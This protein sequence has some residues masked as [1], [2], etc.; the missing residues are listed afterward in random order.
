MSLGKEMRLRRLMRP[1]TGRCV[2]LA[3]SH[4]TSTVEIFPELERT[5][6][7]LDASLAGG[8]DCVLM[9]AGFARATQTIW[10]KY[11]GKGFVAKI[12]A[13]SYVDVP[14]EVQ[15][16]SVAEAADLGADGVGLLMQL[17]PSTEDSVLRLVAS[18]GEECA[19]RGMPYLVEAELPGAYS[20]GA[21]LPDDVVAYLRRSCRLAQELGADIIKT[22]W[23]G[24]AEAFAS[25]IA[26]VTQP[27]V[28][29][30]GAKTTEEEL[31][32]RIAAALRM[33]AAGAS[34]GRNI[35]I[36]DDPGQATAQIASVVHRDPTAARLSA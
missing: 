20:Q 15:I 14:R 36:S 8:A 28:V 27:V 26:P 21:W 1:D 2:L 12:S 31:L 9:S 17:T 6:E 33:G 13:T 35:F 10:S 5:A 24:S 3:L 29:A 11:P 16:L 25:V 4:G 19:K 22:N 23:P 32:T 34:V 18:V 30:G 7:V